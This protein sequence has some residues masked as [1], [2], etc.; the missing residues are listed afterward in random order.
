MMMFMSIFSTHKL[1][2]NALM[3]LGEENHTKIELCNAVN[4][5]IKPEAKD[6]LTSRSWHFIEGKK[7]I[8]LV[9]DH[10]DS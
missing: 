4:F 6:W 10:V 2:Y 1:S 5:N 9:K 7:L 8:E 3:K